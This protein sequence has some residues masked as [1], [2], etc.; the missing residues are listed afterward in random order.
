MR[1]YLIHHATAFKIEED[2][3]RHLTELGRSQADRLGARFAAAGVDPVRILHSD[4][5]WVLETAERI[6]AVMGMSDRTAVAGYEIN[7]DDPIEPFLA[8]IEKA[9][10]DIMMVG[11]VKYLRRAAAQLVTGDE[12]LEVI[13]FKPDFGSAFCLED[14]DGDWTVRFGW[15]QEHAAG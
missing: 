4:K 14:E 9:D 1:V 8:E 13:A 10:G 6:A 3:E 2:P 12:T 7:T 5:Q 15:R 11:H